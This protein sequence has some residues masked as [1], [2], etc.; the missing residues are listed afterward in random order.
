MHQTWYPNGTLKSERLYKDDL[1]E[2]SAQSWHEN[3]QIKSSYF[4]KNGEP[5]GSFQEWHDNGQ[6]QSFYIIDYN[7]ILLE[8]FLVG[9]LWYFIWG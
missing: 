7:V 5:H 4:Y 6:I 3:G 9:E 8:D 2:G 1:P